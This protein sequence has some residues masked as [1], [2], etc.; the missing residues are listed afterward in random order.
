MVDRIRV[1][2]AWP[3]DLAAA[4]PCREEEALL[5]ALRQPDYPALASC[6]ICDEPPESV[7][8]CVED[9]TAD[10]CSVVLVDFKP[11]RHGIRVPTDA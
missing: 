10:G 1:T 8:S 4:L 5:G 2:G 9:P 7:V 11:C 3:T 6:P